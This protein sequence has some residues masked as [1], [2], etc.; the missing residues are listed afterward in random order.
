MNTL[1]RSF[2]VIATIGSA[3]AIEETQKKV[4]P[5]LEGQTVF[6]TFGMVIV[7]PKGVELPPKGYEGAMRGTEPLAIMKI[8]GKVVGEVY[9]NPLKGT[10]KDEADGMSRSADKSP[11]I[12]L[13]KRGAAVRAKLPHEITTLRMDTPSKLG[14]PWIIH[15][16]YFARGDHTVTFKFVA[17][18]K[19]F[20]RVLPLFE[21]MVFAQEFMKN[22]VKESDAGAPKQDEEQ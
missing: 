7:H 17:G 2:V 9:G 12:T 22:P 10:A 4:V 14:K 3:I 11:S 16:L 13:L 19:D 6:L 15:S 21:A 5:D 20:E 18:E 8:D 1:I